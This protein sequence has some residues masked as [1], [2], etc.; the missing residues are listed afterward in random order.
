MQQLQL[1]ILTNE[2]KQISELNHLFDDDQDK[3]YYCL[4]R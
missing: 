4:N 1:E 3:R 2:I